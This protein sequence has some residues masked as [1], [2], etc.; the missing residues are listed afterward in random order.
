M[1]V[2]LDDLQEIADSLSSPVV[3]CHNDLLAPNII[4]NE[5]TSNRSEHKVGWFGDDV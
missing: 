3:F 5:H 4:Y 1:D 2:Q